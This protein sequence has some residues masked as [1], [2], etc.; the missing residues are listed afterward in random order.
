MARCRP[1]TCTGTETEARNVAPF[2]KK[3]SSVDSNRPT[4]TNG[5]EFFSVVKK[6]PSATGGVVR[7]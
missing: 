5:S 6:T 7:I 1:T 4:V 2:L 3:P